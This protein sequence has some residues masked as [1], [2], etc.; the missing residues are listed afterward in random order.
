M[1]HSKLN[2]KN[3]G[4]TF[5]FRPA[6]IAKDSFNF[7]ICPL[8][9]YFLVQVSSTPLWLRKA[10]AAVLGIPETDFLEDDSEKDEGVESKMNKL[11]DSTTWLA[12]MLTETPINDRHLQRKV[13][14]LNTAIDGAKEAHNDYAASLDNEEARGAAALEF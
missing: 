13:D 2:R 3:W 1:K 7:N 4:L 12:K 10:F 6:I 8:E 5:K 11:K 14:D 9:G